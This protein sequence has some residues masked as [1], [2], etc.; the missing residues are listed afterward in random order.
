V[1]LERR[2]AGLGAVNAL[3]PEQHEALNAK[4]TTISVQRDDLARASSSLRAMARQLEREIEQR[5][6]TVFGAVSFHFQELYAELFPG[7][8]ATLRLEEPVQP[9]LDLDGVAP[10]VAE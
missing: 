10:L 2:I 5:F 3:A 8:K 9:A 1:R 4:V 7:G 6:D